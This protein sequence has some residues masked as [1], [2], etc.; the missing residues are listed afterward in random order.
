MMSKKLKLG[1]VG[2]GNMG[3]SHVSTLMQLEN[4]ELVGVCDIIH[5][6]ADYF[7]QKAHTTAYYS[8]TDMMERSGL[9]A[10]QIAVPHYDHTTISVEAFQ[11][12]LHVLCEKPLAVHINDA[13]KSNRAYEE[14]LKQNPNLVFG[15]MFQERTLPHYRKIKQLIDSGVLGRLTRVTW[16][17]TTRFRTQCYYNSGGWRATWAGEGGGILTNQCPHTLDMYQWLFGVP[18]TIS[19]YA[20]IGKYHDI[21]VE[22]EVSACL[23]H[24]N[25]MIGNLIVTTAEAPGTNRL[26]IAGE[27]GKLVYENNQLILWRNEV[28]MLELIKTSDKVFDS[29]QSEPEEIVYEDNLPSGHRVVLEHFIK[30]ALGDKC[31][32]IADG[33]E[34]LN[35]VEIANGIMLSHFKGCPV[36]IATCGD[37]FE[38]KLRAL[39]ASSKFVK[40]VCEQTAT[41]MEDSFS[42]K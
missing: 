10:I 24:E 34:G 35:S 14:A 18:K 13:L 23:I 41:N 2:L 4:V 29:I 12:G 3:S 21:E 8:S 33:R 26:E 19:A 31:S 30:R 17:D 40:H 7:A 39:I 36:E 27:N 1:I 6:K 16:I 28:S 15:I 5:E 11:R 9:E 32:L 20:A 22:D 42:Q 37:E 25:G 38:E